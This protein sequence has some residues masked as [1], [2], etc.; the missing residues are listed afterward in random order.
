[1]ADTRPVGGRR[2]VGSQSAE[3]GD[4]A[5]RSAEGGD[6]AVRSAE[7]GYAAVRSAEGGDAGQRHAD[8]EGVDLIGAFVGQNRLEVVGVA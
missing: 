8:R 7:G 2:T 4:A 6:A 3:G 5:V 1:M